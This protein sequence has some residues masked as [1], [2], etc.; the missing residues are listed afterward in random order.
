MSDRKIFVGTYASYNEGILYGNWV[1]LDNYSSF[2]AFAEDIQKIINKCPMKGEEYDI[3]DHEGFGNTIS[4]S[5]SL[6]EIWEA[7]EKLNELEKLDI[8][9]EVASEV[10]ADFSDVEIF[11]ENYLGRFDSIED[12][13]QQFFDDC[14]QTEGVPEIFIRYFDI[15]SFAR[16]LSFDLYIVEHK[17]YS[18][19]FNNI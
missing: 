19:I 1:E 13:A 2:D 14:Y 17:G 5:P 9:N 4:N 15:N 6:S 11:S 8:P 16:D 3:Q 10:L 18:Y 12:Y 7:H